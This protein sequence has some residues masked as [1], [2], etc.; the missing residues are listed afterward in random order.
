MYRVIV[1]DDEEAVRDRLISLV[2]KLKADFQLVG[3][4]ENGYDAL[5]GIEQL[6]PDLLITDIKMPYIDGIELIKQAKLEVPLM[7]TIIISGYDSFDYAK[8]AIDLKVIGYITKPISFDELKEAMYKAKTELD[9][10]LSID[11]NIESLQEQAKTNLSL[12]QENDLCKL[13]SL[14]DVP[15]NFRKKL[16]ID[17]INIKEKYCVLGIFDFDEEFDKIGYETSEVVNIYLHRYL[18]DEFDEQYSIYVF[19]RSNQVLFLA[20]SQKPI[21]KDSMEESLASILS[22]INKVC[23]IS[24]SAAISDFSSEKEHNFR[25][26]FRHALRTLEYRTVIGK[27]TVLFFDDIQKEEVSI[28]K[29]DDNEFKTVTYDLSYGYIKD[30]KGHI[31]NMLTK[32]AS[33]EYADSYLYIISSITNSLLKSCT[34]FKD[35]YKNFMNNNE[36]F[37]TVYECK[38]VDKLNDFFNSLIDSIYAVNEETRNSG[39]E[40][41]LKQTLAYID[42][43]YADQNL[44]LEALSKALCYSVSYLSLLL[45]NDNKT[46]T[47]YVMSVRMEHAK[48]LLTNP[49]NKIVTVSEAVGYSDPYYFS[50]CFKKYV[51]VSPVEYRKK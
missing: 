10:V 25:K 26:L 29:I 8:Q 30:C 35:L 42:A 50:H 7:Q 12:L 33:P 17:Q 51:G 45:K 5:E 36:I 23:H 43:H 41:G 3:Q 21:D 34:N 40:S 48:E 39:V 19:N 2:N 6:Q 32:I 9:Q 11:K 13:L 22:K 44:S 31:K 20:L 46:F 15:D 24:L 18:Y 28:G 14:K 38:S 37:Q 4:F 27:S 1:A 49:N 16:E 47:K